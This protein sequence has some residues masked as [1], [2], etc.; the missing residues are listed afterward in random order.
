VANSADKDD[1]FSAWLSLEFPGGLFSRTFW[2]SVL[3]VG[4]SVDK[5]GVYTA[6]CKSLDV[7]PFVGLCFSSISLPKSA[8]IGPED[9]KEED[10][11]AGMVAID[12][13]DFFKD[14]L[15]P[16]YCDS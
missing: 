14:R 9:R 8:H 4:R 12:P 6:W 15:E 11:D 2:V 13:L 7:F 16:E 10:K 3:L 5:F 1:A